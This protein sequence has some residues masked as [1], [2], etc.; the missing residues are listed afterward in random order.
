MTSQERLCAKAI[1]KGQTMLGLVAAQQAAI[2]IAFLRQVL[3]STYGNITATS[4]IVGI[5]RRSVSEK[6]RQYGINKYD[7][8]PKAKG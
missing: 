1:R 6:L 8:R 5:S 4:A 2:E 7:Y 3:K